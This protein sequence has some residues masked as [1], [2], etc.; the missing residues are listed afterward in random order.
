MADK[1]PDKSPAGAQTEVRK[2]VRDLKKQT[3]RQQQE[4]EMETDEGPSPS[5]GSPCKAGPADDFGELRAMLDAMYNPLSSGAQ[6]QGSREFMRR[7]RRKYRKVVQSDKDLIEILGDD[8]LGGRA[9]SILLA[10]PA[11]IVQQGF[12]AV[13]EELGK[14]VAA[15]S[16]A[17][18]LRALTELRSLRMRPNQSVAE[19]CVLLENL[20]RQANPDCT[21]EDRSMEYAQILLDNLAK[22]PEHVQL[23]AALHRVTPDRAYSEVKQLAITMEQSKMMFTTQ[24]QRKQFRQ[25]NNWRSRAT[26]YRD[27]NS[28]IILPEHSNRVNDC[29]RRMEP[30]RRDIAANNGRQNFNQPQPQPFQRVNGRNAE[31]RRCFKCSEVGHIGR[32]CPQQQQANMA[33]NQRQLQTPHRMDHRVSQM[34]ARG[35]SMGITVREPRSSFEG[36]IGN[37]L[38]VTLEVLGE[39]LPAMIDSGSMISI[40]PVGVLARAKKSGFDVD[41]LEAIEVEGTLPVYDASNNRMKFLGGVRV[42]VQLVGG[43]RSMVSFFVADQPGNEILLGTNALEGLGVYIIVDS[44]HDK[45]SACTEFIHD[46]EGEQIKSVRSLRRVY[47]PPYTCCL[48]QAQCETEADEVVMWSSRR[49]VPTGVFKISDKGLTLPIVNDGEDPLIIE[50]GEELGK[51]STD[52]WSEGWENMDL[53]VTGAATENL[54]TEDRRALLSEQITSNLA[55]K[56]IQQDLAGVLD[57]FEDVFAVSDRELTRTNLVEMNIDTGESSPIR[58]KARPVPLA[59]RQKLKDML[60]DLQ[61]RNIIERSKS[62]WAFPI[63][64]VEKKD[65]SLRLCVDYRELNKRIKQDSYPLPT[66]E[67]V[68]QSLAGKKFFSTLDMCSGYWQIPLSKEAKEKSAFTTPEGLFQF[69]VTP[70]G[71]STSP[72]V[73]QR[74]MDMVLY[75]LTGSEVFCYI[76]DI[77]ICTHTRERHLELLRE[78]CQRMRDAGLKLKAQK[79][80]LLQTQVSFLGHLID[81]NGLHM[82]PRKV[83]VIKNYPTPTN[84][85]QLRTFLGMASFYRKF[86][87]GFSKQTS[88]LFALTSAKVKWSWDEEHN[89]A[90]EKVKKMISS[91]PVLSQPDIE[92]AR[93]GE[94]PFKI[95]TDASTYGLG[96]VLSQD[97]DDGQLHPLFFASKALTKAERRYHVTDLEALAVVFAVR[98]FHMFIYGLPVV[99]MT[100]HQPLTALFKRKNVSARVLRWSLELQRY[101]LEVRYVK[102]KANAVADA[103]SRGVAHLEEEEPLEGLGEAVVNEIR[104]EESSKWLKELEADD[105]FAEIIKLLRKNDLDGTVR[106]KGSNTPV[107]ISDFIL[108]NGDLKMYQDDGTLVYVVPK[109]KRREVFLESHEGTF[110]GHFGPQRL[111]KKLRKQVFWPGM[112]KDI[113][114]WSQECQKCFVS[115]PRQAIVPPLKP[116]ST[117]RPYE[118]IGVDVLELGPTRNG[119]RYA[120][121]VIDH[122][123]KWAAAYPVADKS[124][125]TIAKVLFQR[126]VAEGC[127]YPKAII[128]DKGGEF[129]NKV[130]DELTTVMKID[131]KFTKG[132]N[133]RENGITE[134]LNGTIVAMLR[135]STV[136]PVEWD[137]RLPFCM[138]AYNMTPHRA[139]GESPY[140]I[141]HGMDP[142]FPSSIIPNG[143]ITWYSMDKSM[144]EYK[145]AI[146]QS[147]AEVHDRVKEHNERT[148]ARMKRDY[149]AKNEVDPSRHPKVG[150]RVYVVAPAE[151]SKCAHPKLVSEWMGPFRVLQISENSALVARMG[152]NSEPLRVQFDMLRI[153]PKCISDEQLVTVTSRGKRGRKP[154]VA[155]VK[156]ITSPCFSGVKI[157]NVRMAGHVQFICKDNCLAKAKL[158]DLKGVHFPGAFAKEPVI[159]VWN[160]W[161]AA[162]LFIRTD[163]DMAEKVKHHTNGVISPDA[164]A[165]VAVLR[166]AYDRC[167]DWTAFICSTAGVNKHVNVDGY[168]VTP[169]LDHAVKV[170]RME[171]LEGEK[172]NRPEK[173]GGT[174]YASPVYGRILEKDGRRGSLETQIVTTFRHVRDVLDGWQHMRNWVIVWPVELNVTGELVKE[175]IDRCK[176]HFEEGGVIVTAWTPVM[177]SNVEMWKNTMG[178]WLTIDGILAK[179]AR[180]SQFYTTSRT[181]MENGRL[182]TEVSND[183]L[184]GPITFEEASAGDCL[185]NFTVGMYSCIDVTVTFSASAFGII[186]TLLVPSI[187]LVIASWLHFWVHGS[188]SVPRTISAALPFFLFAVLFVREMISSGLIR[189]S[190]SDKGGEFVVIPQQL[191]KAITEEHLRDDTLYRTSSAKEFQAQY[192]HLN[193]EWVKVARTAGLPRSFIARLKIELPSCPVLYLLVKTHKLSL[194]EEFASMDPTVFKVRPIISCVGGPTDRIAWFLNVILAQLLS[195]IPSHLTNTQMFLNR[196]RSMQLEHNCVVESFDVTALYTNVSNERALQAI[197]E[198][199]IEYQGNI[200]MHGLAVAQIMVLLQECLRCTIF[201]WSGNYFAQ[202]RGLAMGQRLAPTLAIAFMSRIEAP[203]LELCPLL[204]CRYIDDCFVVCTTQEEMDM[205]FELLN[206]QSEHIKFTREKPKNDWLPFLNVQV[207]IRGGSRVTKWYRKPNNKNIIVH[208]RSAH[209]QQMKRAVVKNMFRTAAEVCSGEA[210]RKESIALAKHIAASNGYKLFRRDVVAA[211][212]G[213]CCWFIFCLVITFLSLLE[214]FV[215]ICCGIRRSIRYTANGHPEENPIGAAKETLEVAYDTRCANFRNNNG[216]DIIARVLFPLIFIIFL[217]VFFLFFI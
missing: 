196:L 184:S 157:D 140:F 73:F 20:A 18:R 175:I 127:R 108:D 16:T 26:N 153:V 120:V 217:V 38:W 14:L 47:M 162:S 80:V 141:L 82:D 68:L 5:G 142:E 9:K 204:Y 117:A 215:V 43:Q 53:A 183:L 23:I 34:I 149:D 67:A 150:D 50:N 136:V 188:W 128:S 81:A 197:F 148:R 37:Q 176:K 151:K 101:N 132:Y 64:L 205:C 22:W 17:G 95:F 54:S 46:E 146:L 147:M 2:A 60:E 212:P 72:P 77:I 130:M 41:T 178:L 83:E 25:G 90:F 201:R 214:Y 182:F 166:L 3:G 172:Q 104:A 71:L 85:K 143:G 28:G 57:E 111:L 216:I 48:I 59:V 88:C 198:L 105:Q 131:H 180:A 94:R 202:T 125:E 211:A 155:H 91:G 194:V 113:M 137:E 61:R 107:R 115:N 84:I 76:D 51:W 69:T 190:T 138:M 213:L 63:V 99:V 4:V 165:L 199:L 206:N 171:M 109:E 123:S 1:K 159:T 169:L 161:K 192:R 119:N 40:L 170:V 21:L 103:L 92:K 30:Q 32:H 102:G 163:I 207:H 7:F 187:L 210:E 55:S 156:L 121:T 6:Q 174:G 89:R 158:G 179:L 168:D 65:G 177:R 106:L 31:T 209:P 39:N 195:Y 154:R 193:R 79:C 29:S 191:D 75:D 86:C 44:K 126:W 152:Q 27:T 116:I 58:L 8:H 98:R 189:L 49:G 114:K 78:I 208:C 173:T 96:A 13:A 36:L 100:D 56:V 122:F 74:M 129:E 45:E 42:D 93:S 87:L 10:L 139:T 62:D 134:R 66:V 112:A 203:V 181:R 110:A 124:A 200:N 135:R 186:G 144:D 164:K 52:K 33:R 35:H 185:G 19:F 15:D 24:E 70:F 12:E 11:A 118:L 133:P 167:R 97:G 160:A 145:T